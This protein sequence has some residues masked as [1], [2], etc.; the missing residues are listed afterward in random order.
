[1]SLLL[2]RLVRV[3]RD[4][5]FGTVIDTVFVI[6]G[7]ERENQLLLNDALGGFMGKR[8]RDSNF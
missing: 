6:A 8:V 2:R 1:M 4:A 3:Y 5:H 7:I